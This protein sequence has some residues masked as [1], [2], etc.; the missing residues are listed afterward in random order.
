MRNAL[1]CAAVAS[2]LGVLALA[3]GVRSQPNAWDRKALPE[4]E[5]GEP[6][7]TTAVA[8]TA[9]AQNA[10]R[11]SPPKFQVDPL[12]PKPLANHWLF[13]SITG[14]AIDAQDRIWVVHRGGDSLNA[15]TEMSA[16]TKPPTA[17][18]CCVPAPQVL[19]FDQAGAL[20]AHWGGP[21]T[22]YDWPRS[23]GGIAIDAKGN[24]WIAAA[25]VAEA[26]PASGRG[27]AQPAPAVAAKTDAHVLKFS[28][29]GKFLLQIG[30]P[31]EPGANDSRTGLNRPAAL[32]IDSAANELYVADGFAN[33]RVVVFDAETGAYKRHWGAYGAAPGDE[34]LGPYDPSAG[35][36][37]HFRTVS[38]VK[39][40]KDGL[41]YVCD[42]RNDRIQVFQKNG[43]FVKEAFVSKSTL[44]EG[45]VWDIAF[46]S[47]PAQQ[48]LFV[49][50]GQDQKVFVL[51][52]DTLEVAA[53]VGGGGRWPGAFFGVGSVA[54]DSRGNL[55]TG[56]NLEGKRVQKF[57]VK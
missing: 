31:G 41:V 7:A 47:D 45:S 13:G 21:G 46:S 17:D 37:K 22:G 27:T 30:K 3:D 20:A 2:T 33:R 14:V 39:I 12:W 11:T 26:P 34:T 48:F 24:V 42:R 56:E 19:V 29:A 8:G 36:S 15:R 32:D 44:G 23:P 1:V 54:L 10:S 18:E 49:A 38:C 57:L 6:G 43:T 51:R 5:S 55:Y 40:A 4:A 50:D 35:P 16:A 25:G 9:R 52:R 28:A 53:T